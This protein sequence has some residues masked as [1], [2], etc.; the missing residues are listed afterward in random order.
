MIQ[1]VTG[2]RFLG[3]FLGNHSERDEYVMSKVRKWMGHVMCWLGQ[4]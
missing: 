4:L 2:H 1:A 3:E